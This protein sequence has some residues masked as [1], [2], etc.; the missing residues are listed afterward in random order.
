MMASCVVLATLAILPYER[1]ELRGEDGAAEERERLGR[2]ANILGLSAD[3]KRGA[4]GTRALVGQRRRP[5]RL[6]SLLAARA[7][8]AL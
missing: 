8:C 7:L 3:A 5:S 2:M 1:S 6:S 4:L